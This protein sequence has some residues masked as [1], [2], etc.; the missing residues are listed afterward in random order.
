MVLTSSPPVKRAEARLAVT[1]LVRGVA[2]QAQRHWKAG[3]SFRKIRGIHVC[4]PKGEPYPLNRI[5]A[6][7]S[8][9]KLDSRLSF[10][11]SVIP[12]IVSREV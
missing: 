11:P 3:A 1:D 9:R 8:R 5:L 7:A 2:A 6:V 10:Q 4:Y 12:G